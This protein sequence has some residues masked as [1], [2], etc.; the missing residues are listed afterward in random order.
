MPK[1]NSAACELGSITFPR[2]R[3]F[4]SK[5]LLSG[6]LWPGTCLALHRAVLG[7]LLPAKP[8]HP[9]YNLRILF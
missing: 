7:E 9:L 1:K 5:L 6:A 4:F 8:A 3:D 2:G